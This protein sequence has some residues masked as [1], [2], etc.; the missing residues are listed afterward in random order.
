MLLF[1]LV[2]GCRGDLTIRSHGILSVLTRNY[3]NKFLFEAFCL[4]SQHLIEALKNHLWHN[5][6]INPTIVN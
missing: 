2:G 5:K 3:K 4:R 6:L 1:N